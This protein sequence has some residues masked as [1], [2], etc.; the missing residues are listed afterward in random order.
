M[1]QPTPPI[2]RH[3]QAYSLLEYTQQIEQAISEGYYFELSTNEGTPQ[4]IGFYFEVLMYKEPKV[5]L[6]EVEVTVVEIPEDTPFVK[7]L[8]NYPATPAVQPQKRRGRPSA[9]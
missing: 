3:I 5:K 1:T 8:L 2:T 6:A 7:A 9:K 4:Q